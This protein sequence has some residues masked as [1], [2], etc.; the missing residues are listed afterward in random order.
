MSVEGIEQAP[1]GC[2]C[3]CKVSINGRVLGCNGI[4]Y[5]SLTVTLRD[6][7]TSGT[8]LATTTSDGSGNYSFSNVVATA[9][10]NLF[11][12]FASPNARLNSTNYSLTYTSGTP[13]ST[14]WACNATTTALDKTLPVASGYACFTGCV[15]PV[16]DNLTLTDSIYGSLTI[17]FGGGQ[18]GGTLLNRDY[19]G[20]GSCPPQSFVQI[21]YALHSNGDLYISESLN[22]D[23]CPGG[24]IVPGPPVYYTTL[25]VTS[26]PPSFSVSGTGPSPQGPYCSDPTFTVTE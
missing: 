3:G 4:G 26:C 8:I 23:G 22:F 5:P 12:V 15:D 11:V 7:S 24:A 1:G 14:Q 10:N 21:L 2:N 6:S 19:P 13:S 17:G 25:T 9:G 16:A 20:C 18:W